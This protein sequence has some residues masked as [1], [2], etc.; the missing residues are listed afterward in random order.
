M[1]GKELDALSA[2][3]FNYAN[4]P[5]DVWRPSPF[6]V[7]AL[8]RQTAQTV[9]G[10]FIEAEES[11]DGSP[12]G[13]VVEGQRGSGKTHLLGWVRQKVH[14]EDGYFF[15]VSLL[16]ARSFWES[17]LLSMLDSLS[18][19]IPGSGTQLKELLW[20]LCLLAEVP[21]DARRS[22]TGE[23][24]ISRQ[25]LDDFVRALRR[26]DRHVGRDAQDVAR[27][28]V[29][30]AADDPSVQDVGDAYL[31]CAAEGEPSER[32]GWG[33][34]TVAKSPQE[35]VRDLSR[36]VALTGPSVIAVD[37]I[38]VLIA[39]S[40]AAM[41]G[42]AK[43]SWQEALMLEQIS[44]GLM[45]LREVT[46]RTLTV[47]SCLPVTWELIRTKATDTVQDRFRE[48]MPLD[49][50][51]DARTG[52]E[53]IEKRFS[54][55]YGAVGFTPPY[56][57]WPVKPEAFEEAYQ[58]TPRQLL[59]RIDKH[60]RSCLA[61]GQ[62]TE[63]ER[64]TGA[65][66]VAVAPA[67]KPTPTST[68][69]PKPKPTPTP[70]PD[71][72]DL[73]K[74]FA[75]LRQRADVADALDPITEDVVMPGLLSAGLS[76]W[77]AEQGDDAR[78]FAQDPPPST[79][80]P[81]HARLRRTLDEETENEA[82]WCFRAISASHHTA[83][84]NRLK[85]ASTAA[86]LDERIP[87]RKL[88]VLRNRSWAQG[89]ATQEALAAFEQAGGRVLQV[90]EDDLRIFSALRT[91]LTE[92]SPDL[93]AW[94]VSRKPT[95]EVKLFAEA[96]SDAAVHRAS[97]ATAVRSTRPN[98][99]QDRPR[100][101]ANPVRRVLQRDAVPRLAPPPVTDAPAPAP[102][103]TAPV[104]AGT[105]APATTDASVSAAE[106][107]SR[108]SGDTSA[109]ATADAPSRFTGEAPAPATTDASSRF[110]G[111]TP[112]SATVDTPTPA[113]ETPP[114]PTDDTSVSAIT[115]GPD[116]ATADAPYWVA[117]DALTPAVADA[118]APATVDAPAPAVTDEPSQF[119]S[120][121][122]A[123][124]VAD[125]PTPA[126]ETP[127][128]S[129]DDTSAPVTIDA[130]ART[131]GDVLGGTPGDVWSQALDHAPEP[132]GTSVTRSSDSTIGSAGPD[133]QV[134]PP[135]P[136]PEASPVEAPSTEKPL[137]EVPF[138]EVSLTKTTD[139]QTTDA[140]TTV[141]ETVAGETAA[142]TGASV[143]RTLGLLPSDEAPAVPHL[144]IGAAASDDRPIRIPLETLRKH[145]AIFAGSGSGK[146]V[147]IRRLV[148]ECALQ[149]V[150]AIVLDANNDLARLGDRWPEPPAEWSEGDAAKA[151]DYLANTDVVIW[152]PRKEAGRPLSFQPLPDFASVADDPDE[153]GEAVDAA[154]A[155]LVP[156][157]KLESRAARAHLG[158][159]VLRE[160]VAYYGRRG[161]TGLR[162]LIALLDD[163]P[164]GVSTLESAAK[165]ATE[166]AQHLRAETISDP[167]FAGTGTPVDPGVLLTPPEGKR[168]RVSVISLTGLTSDAQ[169]Q[170]FVNQLQMALFS[171]IKRHPAV[172]R[173][174]GGLFVMDEAQTFA[175]SG[176]STVCTQSTLALAAQA[177][178]YGLGLVFATQAPK[179]LHNRITGNAATQ[180]FGLLNA[181]AQISAARELARA[182]GG[183]VPD[184]ARLKSGQF[185]AAIEGGSFTKVRTPLCLTHHPS[186]PLT[187]EEVVARANR[188]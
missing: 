163:L 6:H 89:P 180:F 98:R 140:K 125:A 114:R 59:I 82:H 73:D 160:A 145:T 117:D 3:R 144:T 154:V 5:D 150:S 147:L 141:T 92:N 74:R 55:Q 112:A 43:D 61:N 15:L 105:T 116:S 151:D 172:D 46:R 165:L 188:S 135:L 170:G 104:S 148:E 138:A 1:S 161:G 36:L 93:Q 40:S 183:D 115:D 137:L 56:P 30:C 50:I 31:S 179:G 94:L 121:T 153:F 44:G 7:S 9:L 107:P 70:P 10:G 37:Q 109:P 181:P 169:R 146:T 90:E 39:Q 60:V 126:T 184:V 34:T 76:A 71:F 67:P 139:T 77:I 100:R 64:L 168:A 24:P 182:K 80:P 85:A 164:D 173:P 22:L 103:D 83:A 48:S 45:A 130:P 96:L 119:A 32:A 57:T 86:G 62:V 178:K 185:Y 149:G 53:L 129:T 23:E 14:E 13:I 167:L 95:S 99:S 133:L 152:T 63:L 122:L 128:R 156:R 29:L 91:L 124:A 20:R 27:A 132:A 127:S 42:D 8:H 187:S 58:Y 41:E 65:A 143:V 131:S 69:R 158:Q 113:T 4:V 21:E 171:W 101:T 19:P 108:T 54:A 75:E 118:S 18:R 17:V 72:R 120:D 157:A 175:P 166:M 12:I 66:P 186:S 177:R 102:D 2:L 68:P 11:A 49:T 79:K 33:F 26:Y 25:D 97:D 38:D 78:L 110:A 162:G 106:A 84:L 28:L 174:L 134:W 47:L 16:D 123:P 159:A 88:F 176:S 111:E 81:L 51:P 52:I 155:A 142:T 136:A 35:I 87:A